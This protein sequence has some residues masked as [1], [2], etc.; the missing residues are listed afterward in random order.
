VALP[1]HEI[2]AAAVRNVLARLAGDESAPFN[3][4]FPGSLIVR[5]SSARSG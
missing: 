4:I 2:G 5:G 1:T 3:T